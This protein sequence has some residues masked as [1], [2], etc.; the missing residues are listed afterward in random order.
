VCHCLRTVRWSG[1][2][3]TKRQLGSVKRRRYTVALPTRLSSCGK[4]RINLLFSVFVVVVLLSRSA[5]IAIVFSVAVVVSFTVCVDV[6]DVANCFFFWPIVVYD[7]VTV[8]IFL[9]RWSVSVSVPF[10]G[11]FKAKKH[12]FLLFGFAHCSHYLACQMCF[13]RARIWAKLFFRIIDQP[14]RLWLTALRK[15]A[16]KSFS[17]QGGSTLKR[18][19]TLIVFITTK[20]VSTFKVE[21]F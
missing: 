3:T 16:R 19:K 20:T 17:T 4:T 21:D 2:K 14:V 5:G 12:N 11:P 1:C 18:L 13:L 9:W 6:F 10:Q 15:H 8:V 7:D